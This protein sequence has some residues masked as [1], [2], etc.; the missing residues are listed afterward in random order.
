[1]TQCHQDEVSFIFLTFY[2]YVGVYQ[3]NNAVIV[4]GEQGRGSAMRTHVAIL[5]Q[6]PLPSSLTH[7]MEQDSLSCIQWIKINFKI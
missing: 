5:P 7:N 2:F 6:T 1:M 4:S 3:I